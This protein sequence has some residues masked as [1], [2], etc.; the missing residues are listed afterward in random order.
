MDRVLEFT[1]NHMILSAAFVFIVTMIL[2][3]EYDRL[4]SGV[5]QA[6]AFDV[7]RM[8]NDEDA[9]VIDVRENNEFKESHLQD[10]VHIPLGEFNKRLPELEKYKNRPVVAYCR[11]GQRSFRACRMLRKAGFEKVSNLGGGIMNW[12]SQNMP[13]TKK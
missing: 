4:F 10:A 6:N 11:S 13:V 3:T 5:L 2:K 8:M 7:I 1:A 12:Q 9:V